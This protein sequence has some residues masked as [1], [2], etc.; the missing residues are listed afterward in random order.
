MNK[1]LIIKK[2]KKRFNGELLDIVL[3]QIEDYF[4]FVGI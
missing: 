3:E 2:A 1:E 4:D